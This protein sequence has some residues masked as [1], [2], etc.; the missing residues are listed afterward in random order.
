MTTLQDN[1]VEPASRSELISPSP[2]LLL[3]PSD[4]RAPVAAGQLGRGSGS[5]PRF[6]FEAAGGPRWGSRPPNHSLTPL[7]TPG[8]FLPD[9]L[10]FESQLSV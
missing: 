6:A 7:L 2:V 3:A 10:E 9:L 4:P 5:G 1:A 8:P